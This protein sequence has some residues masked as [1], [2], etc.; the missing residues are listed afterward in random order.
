[1]STRS[2]SSNI[3]RKRSQAIA[4][5]T[6]YRNTTTPPPTTITTTATSPSPIRQTDKTTTINHNAT[7]QAYRHRCRHD[8]HHNPEPPTNL[9]SPNTR[10]IASPD[11]R[12]MKIYASATSTYRESLVGFV[13]SGLPRLVLGGHSV[14]PVDVWVDRDLLH[15]LGVG[16]GDPA[17]I[18]T[19]I[20]RQWKRGKHKGT[21]AIIVL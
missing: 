18:K 4:T 8:D 13:V 2:L 3:R 19:K 6:Q 17:P 15:Q 10:R 12:S 20:T 11:T 1:M 14:N 9:T 7:T 21:A 16:Y 5:S